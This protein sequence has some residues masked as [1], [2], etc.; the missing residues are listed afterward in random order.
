MTYAKFF[1]LSQKLKN[2]TGNVTT[3]KMGRKF[4]DGILLKYET[5]KWNLDDGTHLKYQN[6]R[7]P[8]GICLGKISTALDSGCDNREC[9]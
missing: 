8:D 4:D 6:Q 9:Q 2:C 5:C 1:F 3:E 7:Y